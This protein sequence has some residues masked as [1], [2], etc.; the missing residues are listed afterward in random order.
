MTM[1]RLQVTLLPFM[2]S[3]Y[4]QQV[5]NCRLDSCTKASIEPV[6]VSTTTRKLIEEL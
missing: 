6:K 2:F 1:Q 3:S 4:N 5:F